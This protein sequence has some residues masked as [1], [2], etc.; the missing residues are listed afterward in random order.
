[1]IE[2]VVGFPG[3]GKTYYALWRAKQEMKKGRK[4]YAN[5][6]IEG[7]ERVTPETMFEIEPGSFVVLDEA[8]N[9]FGSRN[10]KL[11]GDKYMEFFSQTRK[12]SYTLLW[13]SQDVTTVD[14]IIRDRTH[15]IMTTESFYKGLFGHPLYFRVKSY[16]GAKNINKEK[17]WAGTRWIFFNKK[18]A[19]S[20]DTNEIVN[21]R[22]VDEVDKIR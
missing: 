7:A 21:V 17:F 15:I 9:W 6:G 4:V 3:A 1:M 10:W 14:K 12:K 2:G 20:Y 19:N 5:F 8:Q 22:K 18:L 16:Y 11:F 13:I